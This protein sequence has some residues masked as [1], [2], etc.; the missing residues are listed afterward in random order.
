MQPREPINKEKKEGR[1]R[2]IHHL[3]FYTRALLLP[4]LMTTPTPPPLAA[5]R[6]EDALSG[7]GG[8]NERERNPGP[9]HHW[10]SEQSQSTASSRSLSPIRA[11]PFFPIFSRLFPPFIPPPSK[12]WGLPMSISDQCPVSRNTGSIATN[13]QDPPSF[14]NPFVRHEPLHL[15]IINPLSP[16]IITQCAL[17]PSS[18]A[19]QH[20]RERGNQLKRRV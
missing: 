4:S 16:F 8:K 6:N 9:L 1:T 14:S 17:N 12:S 19:P 11:Q 13:Y 5:M 2:S 3:C 10:P 18:R 20:L 15:H 7:K